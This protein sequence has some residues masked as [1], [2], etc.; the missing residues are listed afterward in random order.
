MP[1]ELP[2]GHP[3]HEHI[4]TGLHEGRHEEGDLRVG[5]VEAVALAKGLPKSDVPQAAG[6][7]DFR[8]LTHLYPDAM[9][10]AAGLAPLL[11]TY[12][13][14][15]DWPP[16]QRNRVTGRVRSLLAAELRNLGHEKTLGTLCH[17]ATP[18]TVSDLVATLIDA[19]DA[20]GAPR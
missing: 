16:G 8:R 19:A 17:V 12:W 5:P 3:L 11:G 14:W 4:A 15:G 7:P 13:Q 2:Q 9:A 6:V 18:E 10:A 20:E 1:R